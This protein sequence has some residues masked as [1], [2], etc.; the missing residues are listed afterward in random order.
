LEVVL[1]KFVP[2][3]SAPLKSAPVNVDE[4]KDAFFRFEPLKFAPVIVAEVKDAL[5]RF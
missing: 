3:T 2:R 1:P 4:L 5:V